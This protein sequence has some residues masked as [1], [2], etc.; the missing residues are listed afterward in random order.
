MAK[1][2]PAK[3][4]AKKTTSKVEVKTVGNIVYPYDLKVGTIVTLGGVRYNVQ[5]DNILERIPSGGLYKK[6]DE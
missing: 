4:V 6:V 1:K 5:K 3:K 2:A